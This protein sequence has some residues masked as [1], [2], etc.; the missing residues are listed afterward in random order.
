MEIYEV[1]TSDKR[2]NIRKNERYTR[3]GNRLTRK[4]SNGHT[5]FLLNGQEIIESGKV[6]RIEN[7]GG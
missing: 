6:R 2:W 4:L 3:E 7:E 1:V 5:K